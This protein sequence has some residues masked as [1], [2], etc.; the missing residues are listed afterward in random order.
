VPAANLDLTVASAG[1]QPRAVH[2]PAHIITTQQHQYI[3]SVWRVADQQRA[4]DVRVN[5]SHKEYEN[6]IL[7]I[8]I[9]SFRA[10]PN[11][12]YSEI[13]RAKN[14]RVLVL[15]LRRNLGG[16]EETVVG[17]LG[18][19][20]K[21]P[22]VLAKRVSRSQSQDVMVNPRNSGFGGSTIVLV[23]AGTASGAEL[24]ARY[25]QLS[26]K[27]MVLGDLTSGMVNEGHLIPERIGARFIM[28]FA[29]MV[30]S[31]KLVMPDGEEL[32]RRGV[33][34][35]ERCVPTPPEII[36]GADPCLDK[37]LALAKKREKH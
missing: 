26:G 4:R 20:T 23:D 2:I 5:F 17:F 12:T 27:A 18:F 8:A 6:D 9:P 35:D 29:T 22:T 3:D 32:E 24:A 14:S 11:V 13:S 36:R 37:A 19:F 16:F 1:A 15:D 10:S 21:Q 7:Y 33:I 25:L 30:T 34:P 31:A 28:Q